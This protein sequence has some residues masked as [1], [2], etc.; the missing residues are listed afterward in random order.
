VSLMHISTWVLCVLLHGSL[1][2]GRRQFLIGQKAVAVVVCIDCFSMRK[3]V[4][5]KFPCHE[6]LE[7][8]LVVVVEI[9]SSQCSTPCRFL[10]A[11]AQSAARVPMAHLLCAWRLQRISLP[12]LLH[13][14]IAAETERHR[15]SPAGA[16]VLKRLWAPGMH[17]WIR[18]RTATWLPFS[19][20]ILRPRCC[21]K[22]LQKSLTA[23]QN[24]LQCLASSSWLRC[25][26]EVGWLVSEMDPP[27]PHP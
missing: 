19:A 2:L 13:A 5:T 10:T 17:H 23:L 4:R 8:R 25:S 21:I 20:L 16:H 1:V 12:C 24:L 7:M 6:P 14:N 9:V 18:L 15:L 27:L 11:P 26:A 3:R 22:L